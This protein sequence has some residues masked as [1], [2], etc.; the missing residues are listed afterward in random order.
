MLCPRQDHQGAHPK[1][2]TR[3]ASD[4]DPQYEIVSDKT[5]H[6][7][8]NIAADLG[9]SQRTVEDHRK[10]IMHKT[11]SKSPSALVRLAR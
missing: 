9:I 7:S 2:H 5:D 10:A 6:P 1:S 3:H 11:G 8:K 4:N